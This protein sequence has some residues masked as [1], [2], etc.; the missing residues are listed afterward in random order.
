MIIDGKSFFD[1]PVKN[2]EDAYEKIIEIS[3][4]SE[5]NTGNLLDYEDFK[6]YYK[7]IAINLSKQYEL[8]KDKDITQQINLIGKL[9]EEATMF[10]IIAKKTK[11][12]IEFSQNSANV[13]YKLWKHK[14]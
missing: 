14:R 5:Y 4:N 8:E 2:E 13:L 3:R 7:L 10:F 12:I 11:T 6:K 9:D 1:Q